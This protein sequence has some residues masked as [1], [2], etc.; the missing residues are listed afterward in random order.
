MKTS[1]KMQNSIK[2][3]EKR[4]GYNAK[5]EKTFGSEKTPYNKNFYCYCLMYDEILKRNITVLHN[6]EIHN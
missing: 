3:V 4:L 6:G 5:I 2:K 1:R